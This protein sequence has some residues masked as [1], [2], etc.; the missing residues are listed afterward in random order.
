MYLN[1]HMSGLEPTITVHRLAVE[2]ERC[3]VKQVLRR[4]HPDLTN[5]VDTEVHK[6]LQDGFVR[7]VQHPVWLANVVPAKKRKGKFE[8]ASTSGTQMKLVSKRTP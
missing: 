4:M 2:P 3:P 1:G 7:E 5:K 8:F 6:L